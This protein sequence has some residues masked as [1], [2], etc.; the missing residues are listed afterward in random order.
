MDVKS[1]FLCGDLT[2]DI[3][4]EKHLGFEK[5][6]SLLCRLNKFV[7]CLKYD[8]RAWYEKIDCIFLKLSFKHCE[9]DHNIYVLHVS[10]ETSIVALY[11]D[12]LV[13]VERNVDLIFGL[14]KWLANT[15]EMASL[16]ILNF[17]LGI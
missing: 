8:H 17:R 2:K 6:G 7:Y 12:E 4:T 11:V 9:S 15:F 3:Y 14:K 10:K 1:E 16:G 5:C 13:I